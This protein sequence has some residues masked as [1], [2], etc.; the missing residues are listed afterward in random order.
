MVTEGPDSFKNRREIIEHRLIEL[1]EITLRMRKLRNRNGNSFS[2]VTQPLSTRVIRSIKRQI[3]FSLIG[4][5]SAIGHL[6]YI[7]K[8]LTYAWKSLASSRTFMTLDSFFL[9]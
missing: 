2:I 7:L 5:V 4:G 9:L 8:D 6:P 3:L 1:E